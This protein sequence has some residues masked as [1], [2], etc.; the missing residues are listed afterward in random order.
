[1]IMLSRIFDKFNPV[2]FIGGIAS[3]LLTVALIITTVNVH[4]K[5]L[6]VHD[7]LIKVP[8]TI[9]RISHLDGG[10]D[11]TDHYTA[12]VDY[13]FDGKT[14]QDKH[15]EN[16]PKNQYEAGDK[17]EITINPYEPHDPYTYDG[18]DM[19]YIVVCILFFV[20]GVIMIDFSYRVKKIESSAGRQL[21]KQAE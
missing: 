17:V 2:L 19:F 12:Y 4:K 3:I 14:Y 15:W 9:N 11:G 20:V 6:K 13:T 1:M 10:S 8:A 5:Y 18:D 7:E 16:V 21:K